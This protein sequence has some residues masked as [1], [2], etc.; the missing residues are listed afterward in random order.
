[1]M[2][3]PSNLLVL[4]LILP[5]AGLLLTLVM[6]GRYAGRITLLLA[7]V[8]LAVAAALVVSVIHADD[9]LVYYLG[10]WI[11]PLGVALRADGLSA[12]FILTTAVVI[13]ATGLF[14][15]AE[16]SRSAGASRRHARR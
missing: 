11:P 7:P 2:Q 3:D 4:A 16:F 15:R 1:M 14:A 10:G 12:I 13:G 5:V 9:A 6:G 8:G